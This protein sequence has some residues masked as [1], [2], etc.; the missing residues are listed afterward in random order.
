MPAILTSPFLVLDPPH[1]ASTTTIRYNVDIHPFAE[2]SRT[3]R[4]VMVMNVEEVDREQS[5]CTI[6][7]LAQS[8]NLI[9]YNKRV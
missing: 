8:N 2:S 3:L 5:K 7:A 9:I 6:A 4:T 1:F